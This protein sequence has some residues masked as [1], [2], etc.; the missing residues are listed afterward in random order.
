M[1]E[2]KDG[3]LKKDAYVII[4]GKEYPVIMPEYEGNTPITANNLNKFIKVSA[5]EP[6]NNANVWIKHSINKLNSK[7]FDTQNSRGIE[8]TINDDGTITFNGTVSSA[9]PLILK[10]NLNLKLKGYNTL[11]LRKISGE[12]TDTAFRLSI[13]NSE[14]INAATETGRLFTLVVD[15]N[16]SSFI[17]TQ[18][19]DDTAQYLALYLNVATFNNY[20]F[21]LQLE[22]GEEAANYQPYVENDILVKDKNGY[23]SVLKNNTN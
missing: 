6:N 5:E 15:G 18:N 7:N 11:S 20:T 8:V 1:F 3:I 12:I 9:G 4:D 14:F 10:D 19:I 23:T 21:S 22:D 13:F 16:G 17:D 2:F